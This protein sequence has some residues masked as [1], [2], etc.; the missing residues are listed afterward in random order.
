[1]PRKKT[2]LTALQT[3]KSRTNILQSAVNWIFI[4]LKI[5]K[6]LPQLYGFM[7]A[8]LPAET[9]TFPKN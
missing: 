6:V 5:Q 7:A 9:N 3:K 2:F 8:E 1:M 4:I